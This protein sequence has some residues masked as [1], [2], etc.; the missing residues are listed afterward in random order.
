[1]QTANLNKKGPNSYLTNLLNDDFCFDRH[2]MVPVWYFW[3]CWY[4]KNS[5]QTH[6][7]PVA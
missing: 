1:M 4:S 6:N 3:V 5:V 7:T 2:S